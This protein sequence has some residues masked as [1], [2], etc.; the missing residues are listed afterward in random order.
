MKIIDREKTVERNQEEFIS[1]EVNI[2]AHQY[3][4]YIVKLYYAF[5]NEKYL[6]FTMEYMVGGDLGNLLQHLGSLDEQVICL[7]ELTIVRTTLSR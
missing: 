7:F 3:S 5:Q 2:L 4:P 1:S 6:F